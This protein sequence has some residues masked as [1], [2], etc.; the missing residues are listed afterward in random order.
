MQ[1]WILGGLLVL[2]MGLA[3]MAAAGD[4]SGIYGYR[5]MSPLERAEYKAELRSLPTEEERQ[6]FLDEHREEMDE[7]ARKQDVELAPVSEPPH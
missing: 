7:R 4:P 6:L 1:H 5:L 3:G 2:N